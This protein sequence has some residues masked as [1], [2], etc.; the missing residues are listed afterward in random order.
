MVKLSTG[1]TIR[2]NGYTITPYDVNHTV[3]AVGYL[4]QDRSGKSIFYTGD[5]GPSARTWEKLRNRKIDCLIIDVSFPNSL[6]GMA[7]RSGH[8]TPELLLKEMARM[9]QKPEKICIT[10]MKP[11]Y[12][13]TIK[14]ELKDLGIKNLRILKD[15]DVIK[16]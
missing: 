5:T 7:L 8:L 1:K 13:R 15:G 12:Y 11:Q 6:S 3:P 2:V 14:D 10:H 4:I 9:Q 16:V